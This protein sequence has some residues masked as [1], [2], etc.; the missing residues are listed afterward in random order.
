MVGVSLVG[1]K[2]GPD[3]FPFI[4]LVEVADKEVVEEGNTTSKE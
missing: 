2:G 1:V 4:R 3:T